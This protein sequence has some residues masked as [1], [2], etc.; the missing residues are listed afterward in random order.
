M[1]LKFRGPV[2]VCYELYMSLKPFLG[3]IS[4]LRYRSWGSGGLRFRARVL[5]IEVIKRVQFGFCCSGRVM[6]G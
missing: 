5:S 3:F 1:T 6:Y 2:P 4:S